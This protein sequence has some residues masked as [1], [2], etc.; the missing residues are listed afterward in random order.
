MSS[1]AIKLEKAEDNAL[2]QMVKV[3]LFLSKDEAARQQSSNMLQ[4]LVS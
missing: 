3:G 4:T 2:E 1:M